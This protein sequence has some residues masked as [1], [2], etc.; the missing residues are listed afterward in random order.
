M[1]HTGWARGVRGVAALAL[2]VGCASTTT[3]YWTAGQIAAAQN[4]VN[5]ARAA[6]ADRDPQA[7]R[8]LRLAEDQLAAARERMNTDET[9]DAA[10][11]LARAQADAELSQALQQEANVSA[12]AKLTEQQVEQA[13][14]SSVQVSTPAAG[15]PP[16]SPAATSPVTSP[17]VTSPPVTSPPV[18]S[19]PATSPPATPAPV[20]PETPAKRQEP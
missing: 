9:R 3:T 18:T 17:P 19:P 15:A 10:W 6:G 7:A 14:A 13:R 4:A 11:L 16:A 2:L 8:H 20:S 1:S 12:Q 5:N